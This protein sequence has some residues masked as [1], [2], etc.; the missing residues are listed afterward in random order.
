M[1]AH[2]RS[3]AASLRASR[4]GRTAAHTTARRTAPDSPDETPGRC[5]LHPIGR[6]PGQAAAD[7]Q[8]PILSFR[9]LRLRR[10]DGRPWP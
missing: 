4:T 10:R 3:H 8:S 7:G 5:V 1:P 6:P 2:S 9:V